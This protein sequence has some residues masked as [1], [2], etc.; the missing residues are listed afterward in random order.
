MQFY[1]VA[2]LWQL[3]WIY[4]PLCNLI[5]CKYVWPFLYYQ[6]SKNGLVSFEDVVDDAAPRDLSSKSNPLLIAGF[7]ADISNVTIFYTELTQNDEDS[8]R[9]RF[10]ESKKKV[11]N[12]LSRG[13]GCTLKSFDPT[14]ILLITWCN[15]SKTVERVS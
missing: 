6:P 14:H 3:I 13:F 7:W 9:L 11:K 8:K 4:H 1:L 5:L 10:N 2:C 12:L 15:A